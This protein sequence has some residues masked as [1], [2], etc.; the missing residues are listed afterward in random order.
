MATRNEIPRIKLSE[1]EAERL[2]KRLIE[3]VLEAEDFH[4]EWAQLHDSYLRSYLTMPEFRVKNDPWPG[5]SNV[6]IPLTRV[7]VDGILAQEYDAMFSN[8]P[9]GKVVGFEEQDLRD[10]ELLTRFYFEYVYTKVIP[11]RELAN[12]FLFDNTV[13][14]TSA[15]KPRWDRDRYLKRQIVVDQIPR[16]AEVESGDLLGVPA[17]VPVLEGVDEVVREDVLIESRDVPRLDITDM[18]RLFVAPDT[19]TSLQWPDC[20]WYFQE[21]HLTWE[22]LVERR[23]HGYSNIDEDLK[24]VMS[25]KG[26][27]EMERTQ[28]R[29]E[30]LSESDEEKTARVLEFYMRW[31]LPFSALDDTKQVS[32]KA[33]DED[34]Y[35][36]EIVVTFLW[37]TKK[38]SRIVPLTRIYPDGLRPHIDNRFSRRPR[39][40]YGLGIPAKLRHLQ[41]MINS[42]YNQMI[43]YGTLQNLPFYFYEPLATG[44]MPETLGL[45]PGQ[46][47]PVQ[48]ARGI[49]FPRFQG[50]ASFWLSA[51]QQMQI[52]AERDGGVSDML[53]GRNP[54]TPNAPRTFRGQAAMIQQANIGFSRLVAMHV[55]PVL[56]IFKRVHSLYRRHITEDLEFALFN[57]SRGLMQRL[58]IPRRVLDQDIDFQF[59]LNPNR[60]AEQ[61]TNQAM[62]QMMLSAIPMAL[63]NPILF[64]PVRALARQLYESHGKKNFNEVW[65][66]ELEYQVQAAA[67]QQQGMQQQEMQTAA[68]QGRPPHE[69]SQQQQ[70]PVSQPQLPSL[71]GF[72]PMS[73]ASLPSEDEMEVKI[74]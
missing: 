72:N 40:F 25:P 47:T 13:D 27:T 26:L 38:V 1:D 18:V 14:G 48:S 32:G 11:F 12:D 51:M 42:A 62:F 45:R 60:A 55:E 30:N 39:F 10:A 9:F 61:Q 37:D 66:E 16:F 52:W 20:R 3:M 46:G 74:R 70:A 2:R 22:E 4:S 54:S 59:I 29:Q 43:D 5:A 67:A 58:R 24:A 65:P 71:G 41:E 49:V 36:E 68:M 73:T 6:F 35:W 44:L 63:Q 31:P 34:S 57:D 15:V 53:L 23:R 28:R 17:T 19:G 8:E 56:E 50:D 7:V 21:Q 69:F 33:G 64:K